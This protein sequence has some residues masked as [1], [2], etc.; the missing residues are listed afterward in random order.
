MNASI[1]ILR[2]GTS[3]P[4][5]NPELTDTLRASVDAKATA[6][7]AVLRAAVEEFGSAGELTFA[8]S[9][10]AEDMVLTDLILSQALPIEIFSLDTGRLPAETYTLM[11]K[12]E[13]HYETKLK[14]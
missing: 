7:I 1:S 4:A 9:F 8:N 13:Q 10:G 5:T 11:G 2:P 6:A 14:V 3:N 12:V